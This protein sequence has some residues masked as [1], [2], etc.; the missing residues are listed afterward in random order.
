ML[1]VQAHVAALCPDGVNIARSLSLPVASSAPYGSPCK[2]LILFWLV[3]DQDSFARAQLS[4]HLFFFLVL[5]LA[6]RAGQ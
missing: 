6:R 1:A 4:S 3:S 5:F 2:T